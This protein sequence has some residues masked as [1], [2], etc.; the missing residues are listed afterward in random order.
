MAGAG[1]DAGWLI[2]WAGL[3]LAQAVCLYEVC[4]AF[5]IR[6]LGPDARAAIVR[7][8]LVAGFASTLAFPSFAALADVAG[9]RVA[10]LAAAGVAAGVILPLHWAGARAIRRH[11]P[12][13]RV[14]ATGTTGAGYGATLRNPVFWGMGGVFAI[15]GLN[16]WMMI[17]FLVPVF[18]SQGATAALAVIA[19]S[20]VGPA[21]VAGRL[22]LMRFETRVG[23][24]AATRA[25]LAAT[26]LAVPILWVADIAPGLILGYALLQGA[27]LGVITILRPVL[28]AEI[29]GPTHYGALSG[30]IQIP[31][32]AASAAAPTVG[33]LM[34][35]GPGLEA[36]LA[37][38][39]GLSAVALG[40]VWGLTRG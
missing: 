4:F 5:L 18:V 3:G 39:L 2:G 38:S 31:A 40:A 23:N 34:L 24:A 16:H 28:I 36:L 17:S 27:A 32:L 9:W 33:A 1:D 6:R 30:I 8:T 20:T 15:V 11:A 19:A 10:V 14:A 12:P 35:D 7:V 22:V 29:T 13:P 37:L 21:Q 25:T 26:V